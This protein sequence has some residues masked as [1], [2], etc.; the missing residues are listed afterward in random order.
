MNK[1]R[2]VENR[3]VQQTSGGTFLVSLPKSWCRNHNITKKDELTLNYDDSG[4]V[5]ILPKNISITNDKSRVISLDESKLIV[6]SI[7]QHYLEGYNIIK[8]YSNEGVLKQKEEIRNFS[9][10]LVGIEIISET[11]DT[12]ELHFLIESSVIDPRKYLEREFSISI[13]MMKDSLQLYLDLGTEK[14][15]VN[16]RNTDINEKIK[17]I[18]DRDNEVNRIFFFIIRML[19]TT[20][21]YPASNNLLTSDECLD[22]RIITS[23]GE[24]IG[25]KAK[26]LALL[27]PKISYRIEGEMNTLKEYITHGE[28]ALEN[29]SKSLN[30]FIEKDV[31]L[32]QNVRQEIL[33]QNFTIKSLME[34]SNSFSMFELIQVV[35]RL[36]DI[37][38]DICDLII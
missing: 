31:V 1:E 29:I 13:A 11:Q 18:S 2:K 15:R 24:E 9:R 27:A 33:E 10:H 12:M 21:S 34:S 7:L 3:H 8:I 38:I 36:I 25:D 30:A 28:K 4:S 26:N 17:E 22:F 16:N 5:I 6:R 20:V 37:G 14:D 32:G 23:F 19:K 35:Y